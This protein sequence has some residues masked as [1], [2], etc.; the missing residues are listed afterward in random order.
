MYLKRKATVLISTVIILSLMSMLGCF[1]FK[2]MKNNNELANLYNFDKDLY[3]FDNS[4]EKILNKFMNELNKNRD[5][6]NEEI[7]IEYISSIKLEDKI[8]NSNLEYDKDMCK[9]IL[10]TN[11]DSEKIRKREILCNYRDKKIILVPTYKF[12]KIRQIKIEK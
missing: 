10:T 9:L 11:K 3:D 4:E 1:M 8:E 6:E 5:N 12:K 7:N 2:M